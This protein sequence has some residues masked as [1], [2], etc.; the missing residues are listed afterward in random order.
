MSDSTFRG[1]LKDLGIFFGTVFAFVGGFLM[2][3]YVMAPSRN[4]YG[5][6]LGF[7]FYMYAFSKAL[8]WLLDR[9][10][11]QQSIPRSK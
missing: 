4:P 5:F 2:V 1:L 6:W 3:S 11:G 7:L 10:R 9:R 8:R